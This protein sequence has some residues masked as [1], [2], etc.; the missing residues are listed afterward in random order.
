MAVNYKNRVVV[1]C[2][3]GTTEEIA[4]TDE[5]IAVRVARDKAWEAGAADRAWASIRQ[6][7]DRRIAATDYYALSD[8]TMS[9]DM[10]AHRKALRDLPDNT[11]DPVAFQTKWHEHVA[12]KDGVSDPWPTKP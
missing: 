5:E 7:R 6:E 10:T 3:T 4:L 1:N 12:G 2:T 11:S 9:D 8:V